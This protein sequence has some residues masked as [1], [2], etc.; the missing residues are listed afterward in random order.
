MRAKKTTNQRLLFC[1]FFLSLYYKSSS[2]TC[3]L[4]RLKRQFYSSTHI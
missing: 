1:S 3:G 2:L 4:I